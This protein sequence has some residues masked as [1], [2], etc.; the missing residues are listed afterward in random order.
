MDGKGQRGDEKMKIVIVGSSAFSDKMVQY[1]AKLK[2]LGHDAIVHP[3]YEEI[4]AGKNPKLL[5][6]MQKEHGKVKKQYDYI[7]WYF[8]AIKKS[9]AILV[10]NFNKKN[11]KNYIGANTFLQIGDAFE[12][13]KKIYLVNDLPDQDYIRDELEAIEF[14]VLNGDLS[15]ISKARK[16]KKR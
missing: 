9:D 1:K 15:K 6:R 11:I 12:L 3:D 4:V 16:V 7:K 13:G 10:L 8:H 2:S 14:T 5:E